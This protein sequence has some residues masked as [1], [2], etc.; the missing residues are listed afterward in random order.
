MRGSAGAAAA[1]SPAP[2]GAWRQAIHLDALARHGQRATVALLDTGVSPTPD[3]ANRLRA[4]VDLTEEHDGFDRYGHGTHLSGVIAGNGEMADGRPG[5]ARG[6][7]Y[8]G[9]APE[10]GLVSVKVAKGSGAN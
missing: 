2:V 7:G 9:A 3:L 8:E 1:S 6:G 5:G 10:T 4:R